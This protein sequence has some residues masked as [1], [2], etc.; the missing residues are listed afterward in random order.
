MATLSGL[1]NTGSKL[2][3]IEVFAV[4]GGGGGGAARGGVV[5]DGG[6]GGGAGMVL[7][8]QVY[9]VVGTQYSISIGA[10]GAGAPGGPGNPGVI[11]TAAI[12]GSPG[13]DTTLGSIATAYGGVG[14]DI[15]FSPTSIPSNINYGSTG[16]RTG[17]TSLLTSSPSSRVFRSTWLSSAGRSPVSDSQGFVGVNGYQNASVITP[18]ASGTEYLA[19]GGIGG[20]GAGG[21][22]SGAVVSQPSF[23]S[24]VFYNGGPGGYGIPLSLIGIPGSTVAGG[25][26]GA[27]MSA[28]PQSIGSFSGGLGRDGGGNGGISNGSAGASATVNTGSGG[29][30]G[31][32]TNIPSLYNR[33]AGGAGGSGLLIIRYPTAFAAATVTGNAPVTAQPGYNVYRWTS[34]P[35]TITFN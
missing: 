27:G 23:P 10:G 26:G 34:G 32:L 1:F 5:S 11:P 6:S 4:G 17:F 33:Y 8:K 2:V 22:G 18:I 12:Q 3:P 19:V 30:G 15:D 13:G 24:G 21:E 28:Q 9:V 14:A 29:G 25:G 35:A 31:G 16:G 7:Y 20:G